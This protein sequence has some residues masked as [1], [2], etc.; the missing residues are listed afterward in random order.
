MLKDSRIVHGRGR[1]DFDVAA[2]V[3][4]S[5]PILEQCLP[6]YTAIANTVCRVI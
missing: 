5:G 6:G 1:R 4:A 3:V 2:G